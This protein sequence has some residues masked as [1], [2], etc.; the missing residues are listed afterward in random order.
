MC[1]Y[2]TFVLSLVIEIRVEYILMGLLFFIV[3][4]DVLFVH[5]LGLLEIYS[6]LSHNPSLEHCQY[7]SFTF[8]G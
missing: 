5:L 7:F 1:I 4:L 2:V 3:I 6:S 8:T